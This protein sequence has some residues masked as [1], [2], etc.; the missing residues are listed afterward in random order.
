[1]GIAQFI[2]NASRRLQKS[3]RGTSSVGMRYRSGERMQDASV[4]MYTQAAQKT[5]AIRVAIGSVQG[6]AAH[7]LLGR[8][9]RQGR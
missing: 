9:S 2:A 8:Y 6:Q 1:M 7:S 3:P 4:P 5:P